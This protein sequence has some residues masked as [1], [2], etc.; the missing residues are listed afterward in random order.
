MASAHA[1]RPGAMAQSGQAVSNVRHSGSPA[2]P[3]I[4]TATVT[5]PQPLHVQHQ[6][7]SRGWSVTVI[8][9]AP[10]PAGLPAAPPLVLLGVAAFAAGGFPPRMPASRV[11]HRYPPSPLARRSRSAIIRAIR[12]RARS[13]SLRSK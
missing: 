8:A 11:G 3:E 13:G 12:C 2:S 9:V 6:P 5:R 1:R 10:L 4:I 7:G